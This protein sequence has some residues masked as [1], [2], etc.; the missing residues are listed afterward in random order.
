[1]K[2]TNLDDVNFIS[3]FWLLGFQNKHKFGGLPAYI[4]SFLVHLFLGIL[5]KVQ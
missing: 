2:K 5:L 3:Q 1:M 4:P